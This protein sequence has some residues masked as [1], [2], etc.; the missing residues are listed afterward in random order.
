MSNRPS[1]IQV[2]CRHVSSLSCSD[3]ETPEAQESRNKWGVRCH[4]AGKIL[5]PKVDQNQAANPAT[6]SP[7]SAPS[8]HPATTSEG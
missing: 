3:K 4:H 2:A 8:S 1:T 6:A 5:R 7:V